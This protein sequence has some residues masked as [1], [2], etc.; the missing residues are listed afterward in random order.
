VLRAAGIEF[1]DENVSDLRGRWES[2]QVGEIAG[3]PRAGGSTWQS[4]TRGAGSVETDYLNGEITLQ[5]RL[6]GVPA[7]VNAL[8]QS[9][10]QQT[11]RER[12]QPGWLT[13]EQVLA[14]I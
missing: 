6:V 8:L 9:L 12:R 13:A 4:V 3:R 2:W 5:G 10:A 7:P 11:V 1:D 14:Q